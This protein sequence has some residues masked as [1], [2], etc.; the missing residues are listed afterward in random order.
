MKRI[1][2][3]A[4][5]LLLLILDNTIIPSYS[6]MQGYPSILFVFAIAFSIINGKWDAIFIGVV[7]GLLQDLFFIDGFG[8]NLLSNFLLCILAATIGEGILKKNRVIPV[9]SCLII[10]IFKIIM[11]AILFIPF[12]KRI[13]VNIAIISALLNTIVMLIGYKFVLI[14]SKKFWKKDEW[15]FR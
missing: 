2:I 12:E 10:S 5:A 1:V 14:A 15:R 4:I 7:S 11:V 8:I 6:I 3:I 9:I 13:N